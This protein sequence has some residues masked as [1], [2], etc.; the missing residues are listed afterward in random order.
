[1]QILVVAAQPELECIVRIR[2]VCADGTNVR[3]LAVK[4]QGVFAECAAEIHAG[5]AACFR[6]PHGQHI[7]LCA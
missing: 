5:A 3:R 2:L 4:A 1:M 7:P 6:T